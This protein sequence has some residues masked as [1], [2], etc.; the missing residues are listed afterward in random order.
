MYDR[1]HVDE[2]W[3]FIDMASRQIYLSAYEEMPYRTSVNKRHLTEVMFSVAVARPRYDHY[4]KRLI[5]GKIGLWPVVEELLKKAQVQAKTCHRAVHCVSSD[6]EAC[7]QIN[8][9]HPLD[10]SHQGFVARYSSNDIF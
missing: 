9:P 1:V 4:S 3:L 5:N 6:E 8:A 2:K 7:L 10:P